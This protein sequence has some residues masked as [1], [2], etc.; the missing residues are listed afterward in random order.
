MQSNEFLTNATRF[1]A[2]ILIQVIILNNI[3]FLGYIN[4]YLYILFILVFP[5]TGNRSLLIILAFVLGLTIDI[6]TDSGGVHAA[7]S[8]FIGYARPA[9]LKF[10]FG[11][12]YEYNTI[13]ISKT[14]MSERLTY[15]S[16]MVL[17]HHLMLF[18]TRN[19]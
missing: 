5:F 16:L 11:V 9:F 12:S 1:I 18:S 3:N 17:G 4:P 7:A 14:P 13:K 10:S 8:T 15:I 2:L 6:F 19:F